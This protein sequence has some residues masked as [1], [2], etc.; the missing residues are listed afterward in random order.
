[1][2]R[3]NP[4]TEQPYRCGDVHPE[5][6][7]IFRGYNMGKVKRDGYYVELWLTPESFHAIREKMK[8][9][10]RARRQRDA[11]RRERTVQQVIDA[12]GASTG[13]GSSGGLHNRSL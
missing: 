13:A 3:N 2:K 7:M 1:M 5:T 10:A 6:G 8:L 12:L 9:R 11:F 4:A